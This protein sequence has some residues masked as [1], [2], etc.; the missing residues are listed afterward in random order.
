MNQENLI[1]KWLSDDL[2]EEEQ[3]AFRQSK[4]YNLHSR[5]VNG[6]KQFSCSKHSEI[7]DF[8]TFYSNALRNKTS[9]SK[10]QLRY[11]TLLRLAAMIVILFGIG[12]FF[13]LN[14]ATTFETHIGEKRVITLPDAS[15][16]VL[17]SVSELEFNEK[18]WKNKREV[19][20][21]GEAFFKV[22]KG[23]NFDVITDIGKVSVLGTQF[24]V[25]SRKGYFEVQCFEGLVQV[26]LNGQTKNIPPGAVFKFV[27]QEVV[28]SEGNEHQQPNWITNR[29]SFKSVPLYQVLN[30]FERQYNVTFSF[31]D[32][33]TSR[34][35]TGGFVHTNLEEGLKSITLPLDL[36][37]SID[38][39]NTITLQKNQP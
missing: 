14:T 38:S 17:N 16:V 25:N 1:K 37:Y 27:N 2:T 9:V 35:F 34:I 32:I 28:F 11:S 24:N 12:A 22:N 19:T 36:N 39:G 3:I 26:H 18:N 8:T 31:K 10:K 7:P 20:L 21:A 29:S 5:I 13:F 15:R 23:F 30:E 33:D 4:D 6:A